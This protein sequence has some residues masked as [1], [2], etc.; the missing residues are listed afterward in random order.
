MRLSDKVAIVTGG[1]Q[2]IG[3]GICEAF[4]EEGATVVIADVNHDAG[5]EAAARIPGSSF[6]PADVSD[7]QDVDALVSKV[8]T[9][10]GCIDICVNNAAILRTGDLLE[11]SEADFDAVIAV[12]LKGPF[13]LSQAVARIMVAQNSGSIINLSSV[14][15]VMTIPNMLP[16]NVAKGGLNQLTR[17]M[18]VA[19]AARGVRVN[20]IGPGSIKTKMLET[21]MKNDDVRQT[22]LSRT[23][24]SRLGDVSEI[25]R[26]AVFLASDDASYITGQCIYADGGRLALNYTVPPPK[27]PQD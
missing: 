4:S 26:I 8:R 7:R 23:P 5:A 16:Y 21:V 11:I 24:M 18:A 3:Y 20:A 9:E 10:Y 25:A 22:V 12:N 6:F 14:N 17:V 19:L 2:G 27:Q 13:L 15:A 1:A